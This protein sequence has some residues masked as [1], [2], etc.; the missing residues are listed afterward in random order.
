ML[1]WNI[2]KPRFSLALFDKFDGGLPVYSW[3][4]RQTAPINRFDN[5]DVNPIRR[6]FV[7]SEQLSANSGPIGPYLRGALPAR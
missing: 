5:L 1:T 3:K 7:A 6:F 2:R 4:P